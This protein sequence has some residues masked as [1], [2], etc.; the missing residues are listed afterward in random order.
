MIHPW[1]HVC[2]CQRCGYVRHIIL[3]VIVLQKFTESDN[4]DICLKMLKQDTLQQNWPKETAIPL[5]VFTHD[6]DLGYKAL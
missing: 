2:N 6:G 5:S 1:M 3:N 4:V